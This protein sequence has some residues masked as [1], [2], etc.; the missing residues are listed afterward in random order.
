MA[1]TTIS[2]P[3][4]KPHPSSSNK[5]NGGV[6]L[7]AY[8]C[9]G[10]ESDATIVTTPGRE[11]RNH[12]VSSKIAEQNKAVGITQD[13][14]ASDLEPLEDTAISLAT[15]KRAIE[16]VAAAGML[17][18]RASK[19]PLAPTQE[20]HS[21]SF[22]DP[23]DDDSDHS[24]FNDNDDR[25]K[26]DSNE[27]EDNDE[28]EDDDNV[29]YLGQGDCAQTLHPLPGKPLP[30]RMV[31]NLCSE[32]KST[33]TKCQRIDSV[34]SDSPRSI[35]ACKIS[36]NSGR[37]KASDYDDVAKDIILA[38]ATHYQCLLSTINAF[39]DSAKETE[40]VKAAWDYAKADSEM[41]PPLTLT[42]NIA[43]IV[44][45]CGSQIRGEAK[46]KTS[47]LVETLYNFSSGQGRKIVAAN[48]A[49]SEDLKFEKGF[50][51]KILKDAN[52]QRKGLYQHEIIQK[53]VNKMWFQKKRDEGVMFSGLFNPLPIPAI[54]LMLTAI[55]CNIDEW[56]TGNKTEVPFYSD[57][58][59]EVYRKHIES[60]EMLDTLQKH[61]HNYG[62]LH[63][64]ATPIA[65]KSVMA[66]PLLAFEAA[67]KEYEEEDLT[68]DDGVTD[69]P[70]T[71]EVTATDLNKRS[72]LYS[73]SHHTVTGQLTYTYILSTNT[74]GLT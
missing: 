22:E 74:I 12:R 31:I 41:S 21:N 38:A 63:A 6:S 60:L 18:Q 47:G 44:K 46:A 29:I 69:T 65:M 37:P 61:L 20:E 64:G 23:E 43:K 35:K 30:S 71:L 66:I 10:L 33:H 27:D 28:D 24:H 72:I 58:Y 70:V 26:D 42:P 9:S 40:M 34:D 17:V 51:Y 8:I 25:I 15:T 36:E 49:L 1:C 16:A 19:V 52:D 11:V 57:D 45:Q 39:P 54:A 50:L 4:S 14:N 55:E 59:R 3:T 53:A 68:D 13:A 32:P 5:E 2:Q 67:V 62:R 56:A 48:R 73:C 7:M